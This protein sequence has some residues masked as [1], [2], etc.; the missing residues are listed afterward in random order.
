[1]NKIAI[2]LLLFGL[3]LIV[4]G[5]TLSR[6]PEVY[7][8][9]EYDSFSQLP[10]TIQQAINKILDSNCPNYK[11]F[12]HPYEIIALNPNNID[13]IEINH[14]KSKDKFGFKI[15]YNLI[16]PN[17]GYNE[18]DRIHFFHISV[19]ADG[20]LLDSIA[21]PNNNI[22]PVKMLSYQQA[23]RKTSC[24]WINPFRFKQGSLIFDKEHN[25]FFWSFSNNIRRIH[26]KENSDYKKF[27]LRQTITIDAF[28][29]KLI[30]NNKHK[31]VVICCLE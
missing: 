14:Q 17:K 24:R 7:F 28:T 15:K 2:F 1:M 23:L 27:W 31:I 3:H 22:N 26:S 11:P 20:S 21:L 8:N 12:I 9:M 25:T 6:L 30:S 5:Q 13:Q 18:Y 16:I 29:G 4:T 10:I 19:S